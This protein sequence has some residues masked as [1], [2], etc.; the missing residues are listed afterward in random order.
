M[1]TRYCAMCDAMVSGIECPMCGAD[2]DKLPAPEGDSMAKKSQIDRTIEAIEA[3]ITEKRKFID[4]LRTQ[5]SAAKP[6]AARKA[7]APKVTL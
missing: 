7:R 5:Q 6:R 3:E 1:A 4:Y 2:T